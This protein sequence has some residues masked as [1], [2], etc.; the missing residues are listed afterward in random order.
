MRCRRPSSVLNSSGFCSERSGS[1]DSSL[2]RLQREVLRHVALRGNVETELAQNKPISD[3]GCGCAYPDWVGQ[4]V[5]SRSNR[6]LQQLRTATR[7]QQRQQLAALPM[8]RVA[9]P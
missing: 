7:P 9:F 8:W 4:E 3:A 2:G 1:C 5:V 6:I